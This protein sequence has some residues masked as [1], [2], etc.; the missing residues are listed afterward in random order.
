MPTSFTEGRHAAEFILSEANGAR[1]RENGTL[2]TGQNLTAG[3]VLQLTGTKLTAFTATAATDGTPD[4]A[5]V[6]ILLY[7]TDATDADVAC[8]YLARDAEVN[9]KLLTYPDDSTAEADGTANSLKLLGII[10]RDD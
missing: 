5:A 2:N 4:P 10:C 7:D 9:L 3:T 1:S 8:S 6:G